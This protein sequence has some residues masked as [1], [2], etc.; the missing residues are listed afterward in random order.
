MDDDYRMLAYQFFLQTG[1]IFFLYN[2]CFQI[3][4]ETAPEE[5]IPDEAVF[6]CPEKKAILV[7]AAVR[8]RPALKPH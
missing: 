6:F 3:P 5:A 7:A 4:D 2:D 1:M 8:R